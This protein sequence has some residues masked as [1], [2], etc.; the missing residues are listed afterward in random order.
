MRNPATVYYVSVHVYICVVVI[1]STYFY[2]LT[3][4]FWNCHKSAVL[5]SSCVTVQVMSPHAT[6]YIIYLFDFKI[7]PVVVWYFRIFIGL[8]FQLIHCGEL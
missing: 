7:V 8:Y 2:S 4:V 5:V 6:M 1:D 3:I